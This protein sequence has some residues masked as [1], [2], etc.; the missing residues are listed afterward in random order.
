MLYRNI[1]D[2]SVWAKAQLS[3]PTKAQLAAKAA[4]KAAEAVNA[5]SRNLASGKPKSAQEILASFRN[6]WKDKVA[7]PEEPEEPEDAK[8]PDP[9]PDQAS[10]KLEKHSDS[11]PRNLWQAKGKPEAKPKKRDSSESS[12]SDAERKKRQRSRWSRS[13]SS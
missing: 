4:A 6:H 3:Q 10:K 1:G 12:E 13:S 11:F 5:R 2:D 9:D 7:E 8:K